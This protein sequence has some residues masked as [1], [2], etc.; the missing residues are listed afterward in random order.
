MIRF[1]GQTAIVTGAGGG[2]GRA[3]ALELARRGAHVV[4]NDPGG[5][6]DG[7]GSSGA[8]DAVVA[9]IVAGGGSAMANTASVTDFAAIQDMVAEARA[10]FGGVHMLIANA[11]ILRDKSFA[12]MDMADFAAVLDVHLSGT[13][14]V[15]KAVWEDMRA[16]GYGRIVMTTSGAGLFGN[17]GQANYAAAKMGL[18]GLARTLHLEGARHNIRV[19]LIAPVA[20]TRMLADIMPEET[21]EKFDLASVTAT[22]LYLLSEGVP[23]NQIVGVGAG[24]VQSAEIVMGAGVVLP[25][26]AHT[27][28]GVADVF[29]TVQAR[30]GARPLTSGAD[31]ALSIL[32]R[33][34]AG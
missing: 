34:Q 28:E 30:D 19:N 9:E 25:P 4:V 27:V 15:C 1:D 12:N 2:L 24:V 21:F 29:A 8:A 32:Q 23:S 6:R 7:G 14:H 31:H 3:H 17:F 5:A 22:A 26:N 10:R 16:Q 18:V 11:G 20:A 33:L 13:A